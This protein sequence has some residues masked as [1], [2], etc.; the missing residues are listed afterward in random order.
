VVHRQPSQRSTYLLAGKSNEQRRRSQRRLVF[1]SILALDRKTGRAEVN[2]QFTPHDLGT[3][4][5][6]ASVLVDGGTGRC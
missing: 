4:A 2:Y 6:Q 5:T 3:D 1:D